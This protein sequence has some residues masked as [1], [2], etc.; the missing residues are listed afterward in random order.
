MVDKTFQVLSSLVKK[1]LVK[2][3][4]VPDVQDEIQALT[5]KREL[6]ERAGFRALASN[7]SSNASVLKERVEEKKLALLWRERGYLVIT[8]P[9]FEKRHQRY[10]MRSTTIRKPPMNKR[11]DHE[12]L[13]LI[14]VEGYKGSVP[15]E[16][17]E[18]VA[19]FTEEFNTYPGNLKILTYGVLGD[20][21]KNV[22]GVKDPL[23]LHQIS[24]DWS[25]G[26]TYAVVAWWGA[27]IEDI[28][29]A[30]NWVRSGYS[31]LSVFP[32]EKK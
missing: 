20:I 16:V 15:M 26:G 22:V 28:E 13:A 6:Y 3:V 27:D 25:G 10:P 12:V 17:V 5:S 31:R 8:L 29:R 21:K 23:V 7:S 11:Q 1:N 30:L 18:T 14:D 24:S 9:E 32:P 4:T 19:N 2:E